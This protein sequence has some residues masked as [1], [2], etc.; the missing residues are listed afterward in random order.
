MVLLGSAVV[1]LLSSWLLAQA[2][3]P[4]GPAAFLLWLYLLFVAQ[5]VS[6]ANVLSAAARLSDGRAWACL[7][8]VALAASWLVWRVRGRARTP[9]GLAAAVRRLAEDLRASDPVTSWTVGL[10]LFCVL[11][12]ALVNLAVSLIV[13]PNNWDSLCY[14]LS[15]A[16]YWLQNGTLAHSP[17]NYWATTVHPR[18]ANIA[19]AW[20]MLCTGSG[21]FTFLV[22]FAAHGAATLSVVAISRTVGSSRLGAVFAGAMFALFEQSILQQV[23]TQ[24]D[25]ASAACVGI[26]VFGLMDLDRTGSFRKKGLVALAFAMG[27]GTKASVLLA[28]PSFAVLVGVQVARGRLR[29][30][31]QIMGLIGVTVLFVLLFGSQSFIANMASFGHPLGPRAQRIRHA[32]HPSYGNR[33][34][35]GCKNVL[36]L[37]SD[38]VSADPFARSGNMLERV[39]NRIKRGLGM[40]LEPWL[41]LE[42]EHACRDRFRYARSYIRSRHGDEDAAYL[43]P[44]GFLLLW[45]LIILRAVRARSI[46]LRGLSFAALAYFLAQAFCATW[47][48]WRGRQMLSLA[49][50]ASPLLATLIPQ[51]ATTRTGRCAIACAASLAIAGAVPTLCFND[52]R[53]LLPPSRAT[54]RRSRLERQLA[55]APFFV[56]PFRL[57]EELVPSDAVVAVYL[58]PNIT[59]FPLFGP[60]LTRRIVPVFDFATGA[61]PIPEEAEWLLHFQHWWYQGE[62]SFCPYAEKTDIALGAGWFLRPLTRTGGTEPE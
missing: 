29:G 11:V 44:L 54:W 31:G 42:D 59:E 24:T 22:Q 51:T 57:F 27:V 18:N 58:G 47:D 1:F 55:G 3:R 53:R 41:R 17:T 39:E 36:R 20:I 48:P 32:L 28:V 10:L 30:L 45:P 35:L 43:G 37:G 46:Q 16:A 8:L 33:F 14:H 23:T 7:Q 4:R 19:M 9:V 15:R 25:M 49:V 2:V 13:P 6:C 5:V 12:V 21:D 56:E 60:R 40:R 52:H 61:Q 26:A 62:G 50:M 34:V 38:F